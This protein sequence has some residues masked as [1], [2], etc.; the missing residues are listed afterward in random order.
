VQLF[1]DRAQAGSPEFALTEGNAAAVAMLCRRLEGLPLAI[2][3]AAARAGVLTPAQI[4]TQLERGLGVLASR[5]EDAAARHRSIRA[6]VEWSYRLLE[7]PLQRFFCELSVFQGGWSL[8]AAEAV[9]GD[10]GLALDYLEELRECSLILAE[11][12]LSRPAGGAEMRFRLLESLRE[13]GREQLGEEER[14]ELSRRH[15][16]YFLALAERSEP[17]L[18]GPRQAEWLERLEWEHDNL[19][20]ALAWF[21][22]S[23]EPALGLQLGGVLVGFWELR[24]YWT[25]GRERLEQLLA[26]PGASSPTTARAR[27]LHAAGML[28]ARRGEYG[29]AREYFLESLAI[30]RERGSKREVAHSLNN[31]GLTA[32]HQADYGTAR[33]FFEESVAIQR[34]LDDPWGL[35]LALNNMGLV[36]CDQGDFEAS[37]ALHAESLAIRRDLG[38]RS[39][40]SQSLHNLGNV[41]GRQQ[42]YEA[43][44]A[45]YME[46]LAIQREL[47]D[48]RSIALS[49]YNLGGIACYQE[50]YAAAQALA[51]E[52][53]AIQRELGDPF[54]VALSLHSL[55]NIAR[56]QGEYGSARALLEESLA[57]FRDLGDKRGI[58]ASLNSLGKVRL[59]QEEHGAA[60]VL[61]GE[62]LTMQRELGDRQGIAACLEG[63]ATVASAEG[64]PERAA[65]LSGAAAGIADPIS[66]PQPTSERADHER[67]LAAVKAALGEAAFTAAWAAGQAMTLEAAVT[68]ALEGDATSP[69][70]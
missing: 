70:G 16:A 19:R 57:R 10:T 29:T 14:S 32:W 42:E 17:E 60:S 47:D 18:K 9:S 69:P 41:A 50:E 56:F 35:A 61:L 1:V 5:Q 53:L 25:E 33:V 38:D 13:Y 48:R 24:G 30:R 46:A 58:A 66:I 43:A 15:A 63:L 67:H 36:A 54:G 28:A 31:L 20:A 23:G 55:G 34:E 59:H 4:L 22:E 6:A 3:L 65:R 52:S 45:L 27:G 51:E 12:A 44:R 39:G 8:E 7:P 49:L 62:S 21:A 11:E 26:L 64:Q 40:I 68:F 37:R 2:E